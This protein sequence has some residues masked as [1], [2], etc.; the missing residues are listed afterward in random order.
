M[1]FLVSRV[2]IG[3]C[4]VNLT[5]LEPGFGIARNIPFADISEFLWT[6]NG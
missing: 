6:R 3:K 5:P 1:M 4:T 2:D